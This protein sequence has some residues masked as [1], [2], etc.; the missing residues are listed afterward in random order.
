MRR[1]KL[2]IE[3]YS[4]TWVTTFQQLRLV[5][6]THLADL[7]TDVQH[8]GST[9]VPGLAAKPVIDID[10][11][12]NDKDNLA[13]VIEKLR[14]LGYDYLGDLGIPD[15]EAFKPQSDQVP[16]AGNSRTWP[17]HNLYVCPADSESLR[18]HIVFRDFLRNNPGR[19]KAYGDLKKRLALENPDDIDRYVA[20]KTSFI[21]AVLREAGFD[22]HAVGR[23]TQNNSLA[24]LK[25]KKPKH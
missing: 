23:I 21:T 3:E 12:I 9:S 2:L 13:G 24:N 25:N 5:Y 19:A 22:E 16:Y 7:I 1:T 17:K 4:S 18:N 11:I 8:V 15:R 10:L 20:R 14:L 6:L